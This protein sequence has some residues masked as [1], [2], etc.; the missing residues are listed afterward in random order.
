[1]Q[2]RQPPGFHEQHRLNATYCKAVSEF[3][4]AGS[5]PER[6][7]P[8]SV[9][10]LEHVHTTGEGNYASYWKQS[11]S[12]TRYV[13]H[14]TRGTKGAPDTEPTIVAGVPASNGPNTG[15]SPVCA[16]GRAVQVH[17]RLSL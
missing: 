8:D 1:M 4:D 12:G 7:F 11:D 2:L 6:P 17:E 13:R 9:R 5:V 15:R 10:D 3:S 16:I 14:M